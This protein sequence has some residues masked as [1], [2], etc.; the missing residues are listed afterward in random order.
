MIED[1]VLRRLVWQANQNTVAFD[2]DEEHRRR[3]KQPRRKRKKEPSDR[4]RWL[5]RKIEQ[6]PLEAQRRL[7]K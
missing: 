3:Y 7:A 4:E 6:L 2:T 1:E 5:L